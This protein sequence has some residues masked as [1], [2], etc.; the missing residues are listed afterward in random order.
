MNKRFGL[1]GFLAGVMA[2][3]PASADDFSEPMS[4]SLGGYMRWY[5]TFADFFDVKNMPRLGNGNYNKFDVMGDAEIYFTGTLLVADG[6][7]LDAVA[8]LKAGTEVKHFDETY[9]GIETDFGRFQIGNIKNTAVQMSVES[10]T[11]SM[12]GVQESSYNRFGVFGALGKSAEAT[13]A[14]WD[15]ISTK[16]NYISPSM[17]GVSVGVS[18]MPSNKSN[19]EDDTIFANNAVFQYGATA[20]VLY[21]ARFGDNDEWLIAASASYAH[22]KPRDSFTGAHKPIRDFSA[23]VNVGWRGFTVGGSVKREL[24]PFNTD[25]AGENFSNAQGYVYDAGVS[26]DNGVYGLSLNYIG[27]KNRD[28]ARKAAKNASDLVVA[29]G[30]YRLGAGVN[31]FMDVSFAKIDMASGAKAKGI[32]SATGFDVVF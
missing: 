18:L 7:K 23:G 8:Q 25:T 22:Y 17:A 16:L 9:L 26:Y 20:T 1:Y 10:P 12:I 29:A 5:G 19:G 28:T 3:F 2:A 30:K 21:D 15:D 24:S 4:L 11:V 14:T 32:G 13:Y 27:A 6:L 31:V